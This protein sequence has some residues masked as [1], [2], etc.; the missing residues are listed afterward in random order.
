MTQPS[1][2]SPSTS[3]SIDVALQGPAS[4]SIQKMVY[5]RP[6]E[7]PPSPCVYL[8]IPAPQLVGVV[9]AVVCSFL[10][11]ALAQFGPQCEEIKIPMCRQMPYNLTRLPNLL[12]H[13][14]QENAQLAIEQFKLLGWTKCSDQ[15]EFFLCS[16]Y[17]P[18]CTV[19][20]VSEAIPPCRSVCEDARDGC[21]PL[22]AKFDI[23]WPPALACEAL[24]W[25]DRGVCITPQ[26]IISDVTPPPPKEQAPCLCQPQRGLRK[27]LYKKAG[28]HYAVRGTVKSVETF[29]E[30]TLTTVAVKEVVREGRVRVATGQDGH[31]WTNRSCVCPSLDID[32][33][34]LMLGW[35]DFA[36]SCLLF[37]EGSLALPYMKKY[38]RKIKKWEAEAAPTP[39]P[40]TSPAH[41]AP[42]PSRGQIRNIYK[43]KK[44]KKRRRR[45]RRRRR[46]RKGRI[47]KRRE[48]EEKTGGR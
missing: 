29:G 14:T 40:S 24:P 32:Q 48:Q 25:Y 9:A 44:K 46:R 21:E 47:T 33:E 10:G 37:P 45:K 17:A 34:Y 12:H 26:A 2:P 39:V 31:L 1:L 38:A 4:V 27:R 36:N 16:M 18:I 5:R 23:P 41:Y 15:L 42:T 20:F 8:C 22:L 30:L 28:F 35:E 11:T 43:R 6:S 7:T 19:D 13:S 3:L